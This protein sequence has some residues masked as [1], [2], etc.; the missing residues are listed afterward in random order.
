MT[1]DGLFEAVPSTGDAG[2]VIQLIVGGLPN[3]QISTLTWDFAL[4]C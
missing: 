3:D 1:S 2:A 4:P